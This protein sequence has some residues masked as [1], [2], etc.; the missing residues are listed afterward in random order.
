MIKPLLIK[1]GYVYDPLNKIDG[2]KVNIA[3]KNGKIVEESQINP[4]EAKVIDATN[5]IVMPGGIDIH[6]H[7]SGYAINAGRLYRPE[8]GH[9]WLEPHTYIRRSGSGY[10]VPSTFVT[11]YRYAI[12]GYTTLCE[13]AMPPLLARHTHEE[14][15]DTPIVDT[16]AF[17]LLGNNW[18]VAQYLKRGEYERCAAFVAWMLR[19]TKGY[20]I[21]LV[22]PGG[23]EAWAWRS[24]VK[25]LNDPVPYF[26]IT[27]AELIRGLAI[28]NE[29]LKLPHS[30]HVHT[31]QLGV[32]G[33]FEITIGSFDATKDV[34]VSSIR[35]KRKQS[36]HVTHVQFSAFGGDSWK[37]LET[38]ADAI[39]K[40]VNN[41]PYVTIDM[42]QVIPGET[43]TMTAD[44]PLEYNLHTLNHLKWINQ[45]IELETGG[46]LVPYIYNRVS[47]VNSIQWAIGLEL[48]L[49]IEDPFQVYLSTDH[50][51]AGPFIRY[52][53]IIS[54]LMSKRARES[55]LQKLHRL[56]SKRSLIGTIDREYTLYEIATVTRAGQAVA[57]GMSDTKGHLGV[58]ADAD[59]AIYDL[60]PNNLTPEKIE[61]ALSRAAYTIKDGEIVV[62]DGEVVWITQG[63]R[64]WV[65]P[66]VDEDL[67]RMMLRE[68]R[69]TFAL[70]YTVTMSNFPVQEMY[71][72]LSNEIKIDATYIS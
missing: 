53:R 70:F 59:V 8:D 3:I 5:K 21:K 13:P 34:K 41:H 27:P 61:K 62:K 33:N 12:M 6:T 38:K 30:I 26:D 72:P 56:T 66:Q 46:G 55:Q 29:M 20:C 45:G 47:H 43:T 69:R 64:F 14:L 7:I 63:K 31:N 22:N 15:N 11:G 60:D 16:A 52:P 23:T 19:A 35:G 17:T 40:Y 48:A 24:N 10:T 2:E 37:N 54:W 9:L 58:G 50:P 18:I 71:V 68:I 65:S 28:I 1:N 67:E 32:P 25:D 49:L 42:G 36:T 4:L 39:A 57:L 51:N 44:G